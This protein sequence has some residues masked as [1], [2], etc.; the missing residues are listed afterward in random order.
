MVILEE[1]NCVN[2][3]SSEQEPSAAGRSDVIGLFTAPVTE[4]ESLIDVESSARR[5]R[6]CFHE[7]TEI[8]DTDKETENIRAVPLHRI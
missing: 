6:V 3:K 1:V 5:V 2:N 7:S 4:A 8:N